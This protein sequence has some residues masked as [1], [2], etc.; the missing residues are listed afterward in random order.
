M[1]LCSVARAL[2]VLGALMC[3]GLWLSCG[4]GS[5]V[6]E[7]VSTPPQPKL[8]QITITPSNPEVLKGATVQLA[9][10]GTFDDGKAHA[11]DGP[12]S[13]QT[14][15]PGVAT[16]DLQGIVTGAGVGAAQVSAT[17]QGITG[18]TTVKVDAPALLGIT[19]TPNPTSLPAGESEQLSAVG[20]FSDGSTQNLTQS[21]NWS[22]STAVAS[23]N[24]GGTVVAQSVGTTTI[25][26]TSGSVTGSASLTVT[27]AVVTA[28]NVLPATSS[29]I[30]EGTRQ[31]QAM[32]T[33][34][35]GSTQDMTRTLAW[36]STQPGI[37]RVSSGGLV[38]ALQ[39]GTATILA[40]SSD[41]TGSAAITV[42]PVLALTYF[43]RAT[44]ELAGYDG[45]IR[46]IHPGVVPGD[47][48][49][50]VYVFDRA[51][52]LNECCGCSISDSGLRTMSLMLDLTS[53]PL[54]GKAPTSGSIKIVPSDPG[55]GGQ[56]DAGSISPNGAIMG[57]GSNAQPSEDGTYQVTE[58]SFALTPLSSVEA[59]VLATECSYLQRLGS[60]HGICTCGSGG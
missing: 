60:G 20:N 33:M 10:T 32:G 17:C 37:A 12:I 52:E 30:P 50:M 5:L 42:T 26:A 6:Q 34:S 7:K 58:T 22:S 4:G 13:W 29:M 11:L 36:S 25:G 27:P 2:G 8:T 15:K 41:L 23:V 51:Q 54:T 3:S 31:L 48:C 14:S 44:N 45:T 59:T 55:T 18:T 24:S 35:D 21:V 1:R 46:L 28:I 47:L 19:V 40:Q 49:A 9:A 53:N 57:W 38:S 43:D 56:C 39:V 16:I